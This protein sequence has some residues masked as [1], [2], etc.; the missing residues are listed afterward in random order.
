MNIHAVVCF[1]YLA[2]SSITSFDDSH[3]CSGSVIDSQLQIS[4]DKNE[5]T[6]GRSKRATIA[7]FNLKAQC[8]GDI[9]RLCSTR[10]RSDD[11]LSVLECFENVKVSIY[12]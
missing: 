5:I 10:V 8:N 2:V 1:V 11:V 7:N 6:I 4:S 3:L 9:E 12:V